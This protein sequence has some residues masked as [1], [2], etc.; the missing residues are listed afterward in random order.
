MKFRQTNYLLYSGIWKQLILIQ[1]W[2][3]IEMKHLKLVIDPF[4]LRQFDKTLSTSTYI[5]STPEAMSEV[6]NKLY[7]S[8]KLVDGYAPFCKHLFID[9]FTETLLSSALITAE[10]EH[11]LRTVYEAR[12]EKELPVLRRY[13]P[14]G[15]VI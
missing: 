13:F 11:L 7:D 15:S 4:C 14:L 9:N 12:T 6:I 5:A 10:N 8:S 1:Y 3:E 2:F